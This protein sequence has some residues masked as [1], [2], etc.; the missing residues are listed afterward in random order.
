MLSTNRTR[1]YCEQMDIHTPGQTVIE[2]LLF[3]AR[4]RLPQETGRDKVCSQLVLV[5]CRS[6][7]CPIYV[8]PKL[9]AFSE[10]IRG[11]SVVPRRFVPTWTK[12]LTSST[13]QRCELQFRVQGKESSLSA[14]GPTQNMFDLI[15]LPGE[16]GLSVEQRKRL[17][18]ANE[19]VANPSVI[20]MDE[21][22]SGLD[23]RAAAIVM[24]TVRN[25]G[26]LERVVVVT[27]HQPSIEIFE[28]CVRRK[29]LRPW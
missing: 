29:L 2:A 15:G 6:T 17:T 27:I 22:T 9:R 26:S 24:R 23:A 8:S 16:S 21:P 10:I 4:L 13:S 11:I 18:I 19:L 25:V 1:R 3:T 20:F 5:S 14:F 28:V 12:C 7:M